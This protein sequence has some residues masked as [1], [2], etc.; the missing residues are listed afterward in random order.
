[1]AGCACRGSFSVLRSIDFRDRNG[2]PW[3]WYRAREGKFTVPVHPK[4]QV[5]DGKPY[6]PYGHFAYGDTKRTI[7]PGLRGSGHMEFLT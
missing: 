6:H 1:M 5:R 2:A 4:A 3:F 7:C